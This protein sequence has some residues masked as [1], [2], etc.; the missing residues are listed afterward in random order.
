MLAYTGIGKN[1]LINEVIIS[2]MNRN[3]KFSASYFSPKSNFGGTKN[4]NKMGKIK[5][6]VEMGIFCRNPNKQKSKF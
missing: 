3:S 2:D 6:W 1:L 4:V 5:I